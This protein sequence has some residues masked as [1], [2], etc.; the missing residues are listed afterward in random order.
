MNPKKHS[1]PS[2]RSWLLRDIDAYS[3]W[4][5]QFMWVW[6]VQFGGATVT[7]A[8]CLSLRSGFPDPLPEGLSWTATIGVI[9][10]V[11]A[12]LWPCYLAMSRKAKRNRRFAKRVVL[13]GTILNSVTLLFFWSMVIIIWFTKG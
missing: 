5:A 1:R 3:T 7:V 2:A 13:T 10:V 4:W 8:L 11:S 12:V 9:L 6:C